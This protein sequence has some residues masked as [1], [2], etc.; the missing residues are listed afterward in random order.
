QPTAAYAAETVFS[1][2]NGASGF[3]TGRY[4]VQAMAPAM[5]NWSRESRFA[6]NT[7]GT[8][9]WQNDIR[10]TPQNGAGAVIDGDGTVY[11][12]SRDGEMKA[13]NPDGSVKWVTGNLGKTYTQSPVLG[14]NGV[15]YLAS[16]DKKIYFIDKETGEI[17]TT[18]PLSG[19]PSSETVIGSDG[20]LY[21]STLDNYVHAIKPTSKSTWTERW[22]LKTNGIV[23]S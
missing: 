23:S 18:V 19:G 9:K 10:T 22:K 14:T 6:G 8:L 13:F 5:F 16:Y 17:L 21:F 15:I 4:D 20:T 12:H 11:L 7:D 1:Q 3:L 2:N